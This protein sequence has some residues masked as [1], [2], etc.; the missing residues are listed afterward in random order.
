MKPD[1]II[2][3]LKQMS[4]PQNVA[5]MV[6]F[7][8]RTESALGIPVPEL[9]KFAREVGS[10]HL[11]AQQLW[12]TN[13]HEAR[14]LAAFIDDPRQV[15]KQQM[16][17][18]AL[19]FNSWDICDQVCNHLFRK[20]PFAHQMAL[21]WSR[22]QAE[23]VKR[24]GFVLMAVLAVHDKKSGDQPFLDFLKIIQQESQDERNFVKKAVNW[25]LRQIGKRNL[26]LHQAALKT[27]EQINQID[28]KSAGWI[29]TDALRELRS[30]KILS[31][32]K[33]ARDKQ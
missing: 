31:K 15:N 9:R 16:E 17:Q 29:A 3:Q 1:Q 10:N 25:A 28:S 21:K 11:L 8:I 14:L 19:D 27:A 33:T 7:G 23:F 18:W 13:I 22:A 12:Q 30:E 4:N 24:A 32:L 2:H 26:S 5:G 20:T 6:R